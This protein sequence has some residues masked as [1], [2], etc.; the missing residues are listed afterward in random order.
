MSWLETLNKSLDDRADGLDIPD[1]DI[2]EDQTFAFNI[3][4]EPLMNFI[5]QEQYKPFRLVVTGTDSGK[6]YLIKC[7]V[8]AIRL[9][10]QSNTSVQNVCPTG[11]NANLISGATLQCFLKVPTYNRGGKIKPLD[12][13]IGVAL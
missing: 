5:N 1:D 9:L 3:V 6:S 11:N 7:L 2:N 8:K 13:S 10:F 4:I 12:G